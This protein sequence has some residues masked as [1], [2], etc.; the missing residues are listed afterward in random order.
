MKLELYQVGLIALAILGAFVL[1][2]IQAWF[3]R[4]NRQATSLASPQ[5]TDFINNGRAGSYVTTTFAERAL[6]R[7]SAHGLGFSGKALVLVNEDGVQVS[8]KGEKS[9][10]INKASLVGL[11][12]S[13]A[14]IDKAVEKD[15]LLSLRWRLGDSE[16]ESHFRFASSEEREI[17]AREVSSLVGGVH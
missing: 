14:V 6:D 13:S 16:V 15:G 1:L 8:R 12:R 5:F 9:F 11:S 7:I 4:T 17:V 10:L 2:S 3:R